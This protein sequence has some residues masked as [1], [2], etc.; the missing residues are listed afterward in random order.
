MII[1]GT[2]DLDAIEENLAGWFVGGAGDCV[3]A[4]NLET[5]FYIIQK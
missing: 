5:L 3:F 1:R 2:V 4:K